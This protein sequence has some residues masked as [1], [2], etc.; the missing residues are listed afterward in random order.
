MI[1]TYI[2]NTYILF[3]SPKIAL[4][5]YVSRRFCV[6]QQIEHHQPLKNPIS[7]VAVESYAC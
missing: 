1:I 5:L 3:C 6:K 7:S 4:G 2:Y